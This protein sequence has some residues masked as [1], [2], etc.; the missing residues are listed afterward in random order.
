MTEEI[1]KGDLLVID[2]LHLMS[3][4]YIRV[5]PGDYFLVVETYPKA[6][7]ILHLRTLSAFKVDRKF[8]GKIVRPNAV[9]V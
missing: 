4:A 6:L 3:K 1:I 9:S 5:L 2:S 7:R 8:N